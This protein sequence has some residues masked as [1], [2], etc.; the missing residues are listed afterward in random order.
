[1][2]MLPEYLESYLEDFR[3]LGKSRGQVYTARYFLRLFVRR[4]QENANVAS[5]LQLSTQHVVS[6]HHAVAER[7]RSMDGLPLHPQT[8]C[9]HVGVARKFCHW[10]SRKGV[11]PG[12]LVRAFNVRRVPVKLPRRAFS[13]DE[14]RG[15][16]RRLP[17][18]ST[19]D[20]LL[21]ALTEFLYSTGARIS[22]AL[23][24]D[25]TSID[26]DRETVLLF[27]KRRKERVVPIGRRALCVLR[28]YVECIRPLFLSN[29]TEKAVWLCSMGTRLGYC[30]FQQIWERVAHDSKMEAKVTLRTL[31]RACATELLRSGMDLW[32]LSE[33]LGHDDLVTMRHYAN[34]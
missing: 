27:G 2:K 14:V 5:P 13:H 7:T 12:A 8:A 10:L 29:P 19:E 26:F 3:S 21:V 17:R 32:L 25:L 4:L 31:R 18:T 1:M 33:M 9:A 6:W 11:V 23:G 34:Q 28:K 20:H 15:F 30:R 22:E 24:M 16:I